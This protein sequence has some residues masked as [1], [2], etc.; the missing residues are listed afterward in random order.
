VWEFVRKGIILNGV[1]SI[2]MLKEGKFVFVH[3]MTDI[4]KVASN[5]LL[6]VQAMRKKIIYEKYMH[7]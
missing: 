7:T 6:T 5:E 1:G 4:L 2:K 3:C